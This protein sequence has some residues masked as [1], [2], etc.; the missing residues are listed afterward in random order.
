MVNTHLKNSNILWL[1]A[2]AMQTN[3]SDA[4]PGDI[5]WLAIDEIAKKHVVLPLVFQA[6]L[7]LPSFQRPPAELLQAWKRYT[8]GTVIHNE[9]S[10]RA[11][12]EAVSMLQVAGIP[13]AVLKGASVA[14]LYPRP[15]MRALGDIDLLVRKEHCE[16]AAGI[17]E[18]HG[19]QRYEIDHAFHIG[20]IGESAYME[21]HYAIS[22]FPASQAGRHIAA[23]LEDAPNRAKTAR[24]APYAFPVLSEPDQALSLLLHM[25]RHIVDEGIGL[26]QLCDW[27]AFAASLAPETLE[28]Q[29][30]PTIRECRLYQ[31]AS[32]LTKICVD[33]LGLDA[34]R[35]AWCMHVPG[36]TS[37]ALLA[38]ILDNGNI[39]ANSPERS[40]S[41]SLVKGEESTDG[42]R[43]ML[44]T[45]TH[46]LTSL[47]RKQFPIL[48]RM[49]VLLPAFW[50]YLPVRYLYRIARGTR[51]KQSVR[52][53][54]GYA[55]RRKR[56]YRRLELFKR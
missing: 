53:I 34:Q 20:F 8:L 4:P 28:A 37:D 54:A 24:I 27:C 42:R 46:N 47:A 6:A 43:S 10:M 5:A 33:W 16:K 56:L 39:L 11:Q 35:H 31:F 18:A 2:R 55:L 29:V 51:P 25:E 7:S 15:E 19:Y 49:P 48:N 21:L 40:A 23:R 32:T 38:D 12:S 22:R 50:V 41:T 45:A 3:T 9:R 14:A 44:S 13:C 30:L 17:L 26:R 52:K 36:Q 1:L